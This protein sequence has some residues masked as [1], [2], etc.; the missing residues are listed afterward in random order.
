[1]APPDTN[2]LWVRGG[3]SVSTHPDLCELLRDLA[4]GAELR[5]EFGRPVVV[6]ANGAIVAF[7]AGTHILCVR[8]PRAAVDQRLV[9]E[10]GPELG[11]EWTRVDPWTTAV[12]R[13]EGLA[14]LAALVRRAVE[15]AADGDPAPRD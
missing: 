4:A 2:T 7:A 1:V 13:A 15:N 5:F 12:P 8:V 3:Y 14:A 10:D 11:P 6:A 9:V